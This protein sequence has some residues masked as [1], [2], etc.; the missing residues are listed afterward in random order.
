MSILKL[1]KI[2]IWV[3]ESSILSSSVAQNGLGLDQKVKVLRKNDLLDKKITINSQCS[4][5]LSVFG[6]GPKG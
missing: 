3:L 2:L 4:I 5:K 6:L 1:V